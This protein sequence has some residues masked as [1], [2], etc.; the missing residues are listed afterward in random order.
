[1]LA[2]LLLLACAR[3][4]LQSLQS[5]FPVSPE[6][7]DRIVCQRFTD[8]NS[9]SAFL[10]AADDF[11]VP[12]QLDLQ[13]QY[14]A[15]QIQ[16]GLMRMRHDADPQSLTV[17]LMRN[18]IGDSPGALLYAYQYTL[19]WSATQLYVPFNLTLQ[20]RQGDINAM[21][22]ATPFDPMQLPRDTRLWLALYATGPRDLSLSGME[23]NTLFWSTAQP[24]TGAPSNN[25]PFYFRDARNTLG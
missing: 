14:N 3:A 25:R 12:S 8:A 4:Y 13:L 16:L 15:L 5:Q 21:D 24:R 10:Y 18:G 1:M 2:L 11:I 7:T 9:A 6:L 23:E 20:L 22:N 19:N 17:Q